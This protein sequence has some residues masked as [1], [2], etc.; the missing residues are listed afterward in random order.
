M[1]ILG[2]RCHVAMQWLHPLGKPGSRK[3]YGTGG[4]TYAKEF[5]YKSVLVSA[6][7]WASII[8]SGLCWL[9]FSIAILF[10]VHDCVRLCYANEIKAI[11]V[12][13]LIYTSLIYVGWFIALLTSFHGHCC[14]LISYQYIIGNLHT[15][16]YWTSTFACNRACY[17]LDGGPIQI[18]ADTVMYCII[19]IGLTET[20]SA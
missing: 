18:K 13:S 8:R 7:A 9:W 15:G 19:G 17:I 20:E 3:T 4:L 1:E 10:T 14:H 2:T 5:Q 11:R 12:S 16:A 6:L